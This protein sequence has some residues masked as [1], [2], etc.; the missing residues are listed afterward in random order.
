MY[1]WIIDKDLIAT[2][3]AAPGTNDNAVGLT[4]PSGI[5]DALLA[6]L[7]GGAGH[8][9]QMR[10]DDNNLC[11]EGRLIGDND[12][13]DGFAPLDDFGLPNAGCTSI[14]YKRG[15]VYEQL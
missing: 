15:A 12:S 13:E 4:G 8:R 9:F 2:P 14:A 3:G 6:S 11:Y 5:S 10:D 7:K 1:G